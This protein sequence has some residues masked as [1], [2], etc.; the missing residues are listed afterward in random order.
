MVVDICSNLAVISWMRRRKV[1]GRA[2]EVA[3]EKLLDACFF[4]WEAGMPVASR[5]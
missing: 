4:L 1:E 2:G 5:K 3:C